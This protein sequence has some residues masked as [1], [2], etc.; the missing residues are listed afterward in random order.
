MSKTYSERVIEARNKYITEQGA[1]LVYELYVGLLRVRIHQG[2]KIKLPPYESLTYTQ[3]QHFKRAA[4]DARAVEAEPRL[5]VAAQFAAF[6]KF[7][8]GRKRLLPQP[9]QM[10]GIAA[11]TRYLETVSTKEAAQ[12]RLKASRKSQHRAFFRE[13]RKLKAWCKSKNMTQQEVLLTCSE[14]FTSEFLEHKG[15]SECL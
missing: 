4:A 5:Y 8:G 6:D 3:Q 1:R 10:F 2:A 7:G 11:Q 15:V 9:G 13:E 12:E 14:E